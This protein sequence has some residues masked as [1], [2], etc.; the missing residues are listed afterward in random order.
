MQVQIKKLKNAQVKLQIHLSTDEVNQSFLKAYQ[1][2]GKK[3]K[4]PGF[5]KGKIPIPLLRKRYGE[6]AKSQAFED[7]IHESIEKALKKEQLFAVTRAEIEKISELY[8][9]FQED[10]ELEFSSSMELYP[11]TELANYTGIQVS[12]PTY[13][14][15]DS[16]IDQKLKELQA[17]KTEVTQKKGG[18][19][20]KENLIKVL[21]QFYLVAQDPNKNQ[22]QQIDLSHDHELF[23][24]FYQE[25]L[26]MTEE[27][28]KT[29]LVNIPLQH[30]NDNLKGK[31]GYLYV[32]I[33]E[34]YQKEIPEINDEF[35]KDLHIESLEKLKE[36]I[37]E[38]F[39]QESENQHQ[40]TL[41]QKL[42]GQI[43]QNSRFELGEKTLE[44]QIQKRREQIQKE[45]EPWKLTL[46][47]YLKE[48]NQSK[49]D[50][51]KELHESC[52]KELKTQ[53]VQDAIL[54]K[55]KITLGEKE[56]QGFIQRYSQNKKIP[57]KQAH[58][59]LLEQ[60]GISFFEQSQRYEKFMDFLLK[61]NT[62]EKENTE[63][64]FQKK[65]LHTR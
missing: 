65:K 26:G 1:D 9:K 37:R 50:F 51:D 22:I 3:V 32:K 63:P 18:K 8:Q 25:L 31:K 39:D 46:D 24:S 7:L 52:E 48:R 47:Q 60:G 62:L 61:N 10:Q 4:V 16:D 28:E 45:L 6:T 13:T 43:I 2:I 14:Y 19:I 34:I 49:K 56:I 58:K 23:S 55:E 21:Y 54:E 20:E 42:L 12:A 30:P 36:K 40:Q 44:K 41:F 27:E 53:L 64:L 17:Q 57:F 5:R 33:L 38:Q 59:E 11:E 35:A 15:E 29:L